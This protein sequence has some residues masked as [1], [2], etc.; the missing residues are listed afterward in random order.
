MKI[1]MISSYPTKG[2][3]IS[4]YTEQLIESLKQNNLDVITQ[5]IFF[6]EKKMDAV[7]LFKYLHEI[8]RIKPN[9]VH[10]QYTPT[11]YGPMLP[12]F[13][14]FLKIFNKQIKIVVTA[15]EKPDFFLEHSNFI[16]GKFFL[17]YDSLIYRFS[18]IIIVHTKEHLELIVKRYNVSI[19][20]L[21]KIDIAVF[22]T[23]NVDLQIEEIKKQYKIN[24]KIVLAFFGRITPKK[25]LDYL[26]ESVGKLSHKY[27][28]ALLIIGESPKRWEYYFD[29]LN[30]L[31]HRLKLDEKIKFLGFKD[32]Q[33]IAKIFKIV[34]ASVLP[35]KSLTQSGALF[36]V[37]GYCIPVVVSNVGGFKEF[38]SENK[39]GLLFEVNNTIDLSNKIE[40][41]INDNSLYLQFKKNIDLLKYSHSWDNI[42]KKHIELY[43]FASFIERV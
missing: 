40:C 16:L 20:K 12:F 18:D 38:I 9:I 36:T 35:Y 10:I 41:L 34:Y 2:E 31:V 27:D 22:K 24:N 42:A 8:L 33:E 11:L 13:C 15:H 4:K 6:Q 7:L 32:D 5:R 3:G 39:C 30:E 17:I 14:I 19:Y 26:I 25:G 29:E 37:L 43:S 28:I 21:H 1:V 23:I